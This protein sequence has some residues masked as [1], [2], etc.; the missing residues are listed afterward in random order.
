MVG[1]QGV[2]E[3]QAGLD[4]LNVGFYG[5]GSMFEASDVATDGVD[6]VTDGDLTLL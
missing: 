1:G 2:G 4:A 3:V 5:G 6:I